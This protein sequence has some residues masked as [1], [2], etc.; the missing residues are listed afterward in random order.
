LKLTPAE[1]APIVLAFLLCFL[2]LGRGPDSQAVIDQGHI[3]I[4]LAHARQFS[5]HTDVIIS[6]NDIDSG[7]P[8]L[9]GCQP[10]L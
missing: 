2:V 7:L 1:L 6:V 8:S 10:S 9:K 5:P 4:F 3:E